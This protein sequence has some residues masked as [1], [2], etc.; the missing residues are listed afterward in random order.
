[1]IKKPYQNYIL[2]LCVNGRNYSAM[3]ADWRSHTMIK[4]AITQIFCRGFYCKTRF[5]GK[6]DD[7]D[8][9]LRKSF[10]GKGEVEYKKESEFYSHR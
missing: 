3:I 6:R 5:V 9:L 2:S 10:K 1:M 7:P 4:K 8:L